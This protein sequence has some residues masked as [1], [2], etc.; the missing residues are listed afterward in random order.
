MY[1]AYLEACSERRGA[2]SL[3][4]LEHEIAGLCC[5]IGEGQL[6]DTYR[7]LERKQNQ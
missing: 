5:D 4:P 1:I 2:A 6:I 7:I 3:L